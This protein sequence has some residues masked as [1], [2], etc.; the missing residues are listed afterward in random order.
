V[1]R[2][3]DDAGAATTGAGGRGRPP[4]VVV[5]AGVADFARYVPAATAAKL[6]RR[7]AEAAAAYMADRFA[8]ARRLLRSIDQLASGVAEVH[9]LLGLCA[10]RLGRWREAIGHLEQFV[11]LSG[12]D[13]VEQHPVLADCH[14]A[15]RQHQRVEELWHELGEASP[16]AELLEEGR[17]VLAGSL[18]DRDRLADAI[19]VLERAPDPGRGRPQ[20]HHLRRWYV[21]ADLYERS[22]DLPKARRL[23]E[24]IVAAEPRFADAAERRAGLG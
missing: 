8:D 13:S 14:R 23:F 11:T 19:R 24:R 10:Y 4:D 2:V 12:G 17:I 6:E 5:D 7:F 21:L 3:R 15:L 22:G 18:T 20:V 1:V 16:S 9:E